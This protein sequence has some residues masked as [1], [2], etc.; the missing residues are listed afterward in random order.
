MVVL[1][2]VYLSDIKVVL[3]WYK[4]YREGCIPAELTEKFENVQARME[5][6]LYERLKG[7]TKMPSCFEN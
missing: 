3:D 2:N 6:D 4:A 7:L 1:P 5:K